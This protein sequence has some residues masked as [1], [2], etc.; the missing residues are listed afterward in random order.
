MWIDAVPSIAH[1]KVVVLDRRTVL[2]GSYD[3]TRA[4]DERN[5][6]NVVLIEGAD[7]ATWSLDNWQSRQ[8]P[9]GRLETE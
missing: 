1:N 7:V 6:E 8:A 3:F 5:A 4:T 2:T 9:S